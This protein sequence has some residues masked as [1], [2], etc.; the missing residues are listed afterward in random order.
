MLVAES[1]PTR[2]VGTAWQRAAG[3]GLVGAWARTMWG[4][5]WRPRGTFRGMRPV[6]DGRVWGLLIVNLVVAGV[7]AGGMWVWIG[8]RMSR[9]EATVWYMREAGGAGGRGVGQMVMYNALTIPRPVGA[10]VLCVPALVLGL[11]ALTWIETVG[12][13]FFGRR[14]GW[15]VTWPIAL[16]VCAHASIGWTIGAGLHALVPLARGPLWTLLDELPAGLA[17]DVAIW[18]VRLAPIAAFFVGMLVF[19]VL[20]YVGVRECRFANAMPDQP[21]TMPPSH[22]HR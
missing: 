18:F 10:A 6:A 12:V 8:T 13:R 15:R 20:V 14:R 16:A 17:I 21:P 19:E 2:R 1:L 7:L 3:V 9:P 4:V 11:L 22:P 5:L